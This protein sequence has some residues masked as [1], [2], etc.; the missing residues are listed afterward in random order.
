ME[1]SS[2]KPSRSI[3]SMTFTLSFSTTWRNRLARTSSVFC[4]CSLPCQSSIPFTSTSLVPTRASSQQRDSNMVLGPVVEVSSLRHALFAFVCDCLYCC[5]MF[6][7]VEGSVEL[8][9]EVV[10]H[11]SGRCLSRREALCQAYER[12]QVHKSISGT[13]SLPHLIEMVWGYARRSNQLRRPPIV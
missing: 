10:C 1:P 5:A 2:M 13:F 4:K 11:L 8:F 12:P 9:Q 6:S 7:N 3:E